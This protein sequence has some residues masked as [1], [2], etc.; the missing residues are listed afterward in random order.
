MFLDMQDVAF[1]V[2]GGLFPVLAGAIIW[3]LWMVR[4]VERRLE[5]T[6]PKIFR[7][8][9]EPHLLWNN[10]VR[11]NFRF[12]SFLRGKA[13]LRVEDPQLHDFCRSCSRAFVLSGAVFLVM[14]ITLTIA[15]T[16]G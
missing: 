2:T 4:R 16:F 7:N 1:L 5:S 12:L 11:N 3:Y 8:L 14:L 15:V 13:Y 10:S 6:H 9:G